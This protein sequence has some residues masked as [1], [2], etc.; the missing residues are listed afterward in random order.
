M[1]L[2][3][4]L[5]RIEGKLDQVLAQLDELSGRLDAL[6]TQPA[7]L[8]P[9]DPPAELEPAAVAAALDY[10]TY[11]AAEIIERVPSLSAEERAAL[12]AYE[13]AG[14]NRKSVLEALVA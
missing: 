13:E 7:T 14:K 10:D 9:L 2:P 12:A 8:P 4:S 6:T 3:K 11:T 1:A 5:D